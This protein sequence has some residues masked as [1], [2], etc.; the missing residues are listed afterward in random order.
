MNLFPE[1]G[2]D[3]ECGTH[4]VSEF[5][6]YNDERC[7]SGRVIESYRRVVAWV[8]CVCEG[9]GVPG[10]QSRQISGRRMKYKREE[11]SG[12]GAVGRE[13]LNK[14]RWSG[15][16]LG[17]LPPASAV[18]AEFKWDQRSRRVCHA[19]LPAARRRLLPRCQLGVLLVSRPIISWP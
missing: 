15:R 5:R 9:V 10:L 12:S 1:R 8:T 16:L 18:Q 3:A 17:P 13:R 4:D 14:A 7:G 6:R 2:R 11:L 19:S